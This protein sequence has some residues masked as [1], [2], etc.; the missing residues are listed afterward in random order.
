MQGYESVLIFDP[1]I[2]EES[3]KEL[4][5]KYTA[6]V[7]SNGGKVV[8]HTVWGRRRLAYEVK[9]RQY[10]VYHLLYLDRSPEALRALE[11]NFRIDDNIIKWLSVAV[12]DVNKEI[13]DFQ[14]LRS[15][16]SLAQT[17]TD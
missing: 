15:E 17:L 11:N 13:E 3:Q 8:H 1:E 7:G 6:L 2:S 12:D 5:D 14:K 4:I 16:G 9:K 10:G